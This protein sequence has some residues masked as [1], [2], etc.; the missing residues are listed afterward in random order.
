ML[1]NE[2]AFRGAFH[3]QLL[4]IHLRHEQRRAMPE[5]MVVVR[6]LAGVHEIQIHAMR[7]P[8]LL[9]VVVAQ[10]AAIFELPRLDRPEVQ[11]VIAGANIALRTGNVSSPGG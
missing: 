8:V 4:R 5:H 10:L 6:P 1:G 7:D 9:R 2:D 11:A 3:G